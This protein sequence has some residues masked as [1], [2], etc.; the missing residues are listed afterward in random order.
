ML[1][2]LTSA[3]ALVVSLA[4]TPIVRLVA[5]RYGLLDR[6]DAERKVHQQPVPRL[7]GLAIAIAFGVALAFAALATPDLNADGT[8]RPNR[9]PAILAGAGLLVVVGVIDDIRGMRALAKL[10]WQIGAAVVAFALGLSLE[11]V[12]LPWGTVDLGLLALPVTVIWIVAVINAI[13][14]IDG[15]D[16]LATGVVLTALGAFALLAASDGVDPTLPIIAAAGG[17][18]IGFLAYNLHPASIIMGDTGSMFLGFVVGAVSISLVQ[19]GVL[20]QPPWV[21]VIALAIPLADMVWAIVR[22]SARGEPFFVA[23]RGHIHHQLLR[24]GLSQRDAMLMLT[25]VSAGLA[26]VAVLLGRVG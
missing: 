26:V 14:L 19:D 15:L 3:V 24:A 2:A 1:T 12:H 5:E 6:P 16:G 25:A 22:R 17:A 23:D 10:G 21:P 20:P 4:V 7:G 11:R 8:L 9:A 13:N 18:A